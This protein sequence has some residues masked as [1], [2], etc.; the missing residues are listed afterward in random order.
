MGLC[1]DL[2]SSDGPREG[3]GGR[4]GG[5]LRA[6]VGV[7]R[8]RRKSSAAVS[9]AGELSKADRGTTEVPQTPSSLSRFV[10]DALSVGSDLSNNTD[11]WKIKKKRP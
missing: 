4:G 5:G 6:E 1:V 11:V 10:T 7:F 9:K 2:G 3:E 8:W